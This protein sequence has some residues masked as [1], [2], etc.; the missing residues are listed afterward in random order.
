MVI[1][2]LV[3]QHV[4]ATTIHMCECEEC[5]GVGG[6]KGVGAVVKDVCIY[7]G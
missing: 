4:L 1:L 2:R 6:L 3:D 5:G 7:S